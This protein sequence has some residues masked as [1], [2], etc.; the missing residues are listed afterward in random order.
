MRIWQTEMILFSF[1]TEKGVRS[2]LTFLVHKNF[3][4]NASG[5]IQNMI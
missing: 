3:C 1:F 4:E 2:V 5:C